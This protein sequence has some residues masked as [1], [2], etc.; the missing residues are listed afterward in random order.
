MASRSRSS[1][2]GPWA[3]STSTGTAGSR[4]AAIAAT[5]STKPVGLVTWSPP[6]RPHHRSHTV[7]GVGHESQRGWIGTDEARQGAARFVEQRFQLAHQEV[8]RLALH[9]GT[10]LYLA[11]QHRSGAGAKGTVIEVGDSRF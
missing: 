7:G 4:A 5:G 11:L 2:P 9:P 8:D 10:K 1:I 6:Q 3:P